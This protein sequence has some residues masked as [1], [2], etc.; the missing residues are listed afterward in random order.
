MKKIIVLFSTVLLFTACSKE[1]SEYEEL[2][3]EQFSKD[4]DVIDYKLDPEDMASCVADQIAD[5]VPGFSG[6]PVYENYFK[7]YKLL[8]R[9]EDSSKIPERTEQAIELFGSKQATYKARLNLTNHTLFCMPQVR[10]KQ[11]RSDNMFKFGN[12][13]KE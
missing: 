3:V 13:D 2:L 12:D 6:S 9:P 1:R 7:G 11:E 10:E 4:Q 5:D 8:L